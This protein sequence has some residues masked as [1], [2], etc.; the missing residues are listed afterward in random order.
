MSG[1]WL[2]WTNNK[3]MPQWNMRECCEQMLQ[4]NVQESWMPWILMFTRT[5]IGCV[6]SL[7]HIAGCIEYCYI[8]MRRCVRLSTHTQCV[9]LKAFGI[10]MNWCLQMWMSENKIRAKDLKQCCGN[11]HLNLVIHLLLMLIMLG[12]LWIWCLL[13]TLTTFWVAWVN[14]PKRI[15]TL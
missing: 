2:Q 15:H 3:R 4:W 14:L 8:L 13:I 12:M 7:F 11:K 10:V 5:T 9:D 6:L 1:N